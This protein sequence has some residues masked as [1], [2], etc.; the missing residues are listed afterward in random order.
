MARRC[1]LGTYTG[2]R[3]RV[4]VSARAQV[5]PVRTGSRPGG[6]VC[7]Q[8]IGGAAMVTAQRRR[9]ALGKG[10]CSHDSRPKKGKALALRWHARPVG[11]GGKLELDDTRRTKERHNCKATERARR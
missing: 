7:R 9:H 10:L 4:R 1:W 3:P 2:E 8:V 11:A 5:W 6:G